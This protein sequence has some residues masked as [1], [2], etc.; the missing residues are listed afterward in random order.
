MQDFFQSSGYLRAPPDRFD[1]AIGGAL[2][3]LHQLAELFLV[4]LCDEIQRVLKP[5]FRDDI[6]VARIFLIK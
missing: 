5:E 3:L 4:G 1:P 6:N 2:A